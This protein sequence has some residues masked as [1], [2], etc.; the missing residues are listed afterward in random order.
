MVLGDNGAAYVCDD[1]TIVAFDI[2]SG[3]T[4]WSYISQALDGIAIIAS[5]SGGGLVAKEFP[6]FHTETVVRLDSTGQPVS[7]SWTARSVQYFFGDLWLS[8]SSAAPS[9]EVLSAAAIQWS[10][11]LWSVPDQRGTGMATPPITVHAARVDS[12]D[13]ENQLSD[14]EVA[15]RVEQAV[16]FWQSTSNI[17]LKRDGT[18]PI[19]RT[20]ACDPAQPL[21]SPGNLYDIT[22]VSSNVTTLGELSRRFKRPKGLQLIFC[23]SVAGSRSQG[24]TVAVTD[25]PGNIIDYNV[26]AIAKDANQLVTAHEIG[27]IFQLPHSSNPFNIMCGD[28][29]LCPQH[30]STGIRVDQIRDARRFAWTLANGVKQ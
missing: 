15:S 24:I 2:N 29:F 27:H 19:A 8:R 12:V 17:I 18:L 23:Y 11:S 7:D 4:L 30:P 6:T 20:P 1:Q 26:S 16:T 28:S 21:C 5:S 3:Q 9:I 10:F 14:S 25:S 13:L 22:E